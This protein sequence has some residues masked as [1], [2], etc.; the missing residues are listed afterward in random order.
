MEPTTRGPEQEFRVSRE[1]SRS[2]QSQRG[3]PSLTQRKTLQDCTRVSRTD[4]RHVE[5]GLDRFCSV[6]NGLAAGYY[7]TVQNHVS[8]SNSKLI[9]PQT[10]VRSYRG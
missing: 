4:C 9:V 5:L 1:A 6:V 3:F 7:G 8:D 2:N 10:G